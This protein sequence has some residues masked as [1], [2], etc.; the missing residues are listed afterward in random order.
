[1]TIEVDDTVPLPDERRLKYPFAT[2]KPGQSFFVP[3]GD[4]H[5]VASAASHWSKTRGY[6]FTTRA[7]DGGIRCW[8][9]AE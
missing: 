8:R 1:M 5:K 2:M 7:V 4:L 6:R 3:G 9:V